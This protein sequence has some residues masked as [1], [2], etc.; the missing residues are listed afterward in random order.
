MFKWN[1]AEKVP[2]SLPDR[3]GEG[4]AYCHRYRQSVSTTQGDLCYVHSSCQALPIL[5]LRSSVCFCDFPVLVSWPSS[6]KGPCLCLGQEPRATGI[7]PGSS[8]RPAQHCQGGRGQLTELRKLPRNLFICFLARLRLRLQGQG[9][10]CH[11]LCPES[12]PGPQAQRRSA[13]PLLR[14]LPREKG[15]L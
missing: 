5:H 4:T 2:P 3:V 10:G 9:R 13:V 8:P 6:L 1:S 12:T 14:E 7:S 11:G 15:T